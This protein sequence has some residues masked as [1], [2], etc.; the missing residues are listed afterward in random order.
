MEGYGLG[1]AVSEPQGEPLGWL[2]ANGD[3]IL[4]GLFPLY[5]SNP[6]R[7]NGTNSE[8]PKCERFQIDGF[9]WIQAM[10]FAIEEIN[11]SSTLLP[12][13]T[14]GYDIQNTCLMSSVAMRSALSFLTKK[15]GD[16]FEVKCDYTNYNTRV[17]ATLGPSTSELSKITARLFSF[18][19]IPQISYYASSNL[20]NDRMNFPSFFRTIP[21][22]EAQAIAMLLMVEKFQWNWLA[23]IGTDDA[24]GQRAMTH[25]TKLVSKTGICI[26]VEEL[27]PLK[28]HGFELQKKMESIISLIAH[29]QVNVTVVF[30]N[31]IYAKALLTVTLKQNMTRKVWIASESWVNSKTVASIPNISSI[32][33]I[34]GVSIKNGTIPGFEFYVSTALAL[35]QMLKEKSQ[36]CSSGEI[37]TEKRKCYNCTQLSGEE[38]PVVIGESLQRISFNV[39]SAVYVVAH[40]LHS[41][42]HCDSRSCNKSNI[43]PWQLLKEVAEVNFTLHHRHIFFDKE[44]NPPTGYDIINWQWKGRHSFPEFRVIGEYRAQDKELLINPFLIDWNTQQN[45]IPDSNCSTSCGPGQVK[46][47]EEHISCC[48]ECADCQAGTFQSDEVVDGE[49]IKISEVQMDLGVLVQGT[50]EVDLQVELVVKKVALCGIWQYMFPPFVFANYNISV[51]EI[52]MECNEGS[53]TGFG[54]LLSYNGLLALACFLC[55][56]M[57]KSTAKTYNLSRRITFA[58]LIY[59]STWVFFIPAYTTAGH[60]FISFTQLFAGLV[61]VYGIIVAYFLPKCYIILFKPEYNTESYCQGCVENPSSN[62]E[63]VNMSS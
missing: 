62:T 48:Y 42:L 35:S 47:V 58:M 53:L 17:S 23:V 38:E 22:D 57:G 11:N 32:G 40:A 34:L 8:S 6:N 20:F 36:R 19:L 31:D 13:V 63:D 27:I 28:L 59:L 49:K 55:T 5:S 29:S 61:S 37:C 52:Y 30:S 2:Q 50:L 33:A 1:A 9:L 16:A 12:N 44:G 45:K 26:A 10:K 41:L 7:I 21:T 51:T 43:Y 14:L 25:F 46:I 54:I 18:L 39:Y 56:F 15:D 3:Y 4:G 60:K 24:Y